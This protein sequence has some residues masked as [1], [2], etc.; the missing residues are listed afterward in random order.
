MTSKTIRKTASGSVT[1]YEESNEER[2]ERLRSA[3]DEASKRYELSD[4]Q[5][6]TLHRSA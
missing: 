3:A 6:K 5:R 4:G 1:A 2:T